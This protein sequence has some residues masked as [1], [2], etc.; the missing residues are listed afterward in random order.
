MKRGDHVKI[1][2]SFTPDEVGIILRIT[3]NSIPDDLRRAEVF[4]DG[5]LTSLPCHQLELISESRLFSKTQRQRALW[6][7]IMR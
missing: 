4:W 3:D 1:E 7:Y 6:Y 5:E 2:F